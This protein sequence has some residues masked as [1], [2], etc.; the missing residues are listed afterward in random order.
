MF[1]PVIIAFLGGA[2]GPGEIV[3]VFLAVLLL[4]GPRRLPE[5]AR[6]IGKVMRDLQRASQDFRDEVMRL[7]EEPPPSPGPKALPP[8]SPL[9]PAAP[10]P[11]VSPEGPAHD[12]P[13]PAEPPPPQKGPDDLAG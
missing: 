6:S 12:A 2:M 11:D 13:A 5:I 4:F 10:I 3:V 9:P 7:D 8:I 1:R